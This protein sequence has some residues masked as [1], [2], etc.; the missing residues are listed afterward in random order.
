[1]P[2]IF[3]LILMVVAGLVAA[4]GDRMGHRAARAKIRIGK[5][6]PRTA[7]TIIAVI[8]G[9]VFAVWKD[10]REALLRYDDVKGQLASLQS[11]LNTSV[12]QRQ[13]A[14]AA[15]AKAKAE[16]SKI[17]SQM[18][19]VTASL[20]K[21]QTDLTAAQA[22]IAS[23]DRELKTLEAKR[24]SLQKDIDG[25]KGRL[26]DL[27]TL[28]EKA[29]G[30]VTALQ[31][32]QVVMAKGTRLFYLRVGASE[33]GGFANKLEVA[34]VRLG[35]SLS[36]QGLNIDQAT[37]KAEKDFVAQYPLTGKDAVVIVSAARNVVA[38]ENVLLAFEA[39]ELKPLVA[40]G[41][42]IMEVVVGGDSARVRMKGSAE[43]QVAVPA[44]FDTNSLVDFS[45]GLYEVFGA[46]AVELGF[47][48]DLR[49]GEIASPLEKLTGVGSDIIGRERPFVIQFVAKSDANAL[50]GLGDAEIYI[51]NPPAGQ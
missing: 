36:A 13:D 22:Q 15:Q 19:D 12:K 40:K 48:P 41:D 2:W 20:S 39:R 43:L 26:D 30:D 17:Q 10:F 5:L 35:E 8:T 50:D 38:G 28:M 25:Y 3:V 46:G 51:S 31:Q 44:K 24:A 27:R 21:A 34:V 14:E 18:I 37:F 49:T 9:V 4:G 11:E 1:L 42:V 23:S 16:L 7:S 33:P 29:R 47:L 32:G 45:V 6:R